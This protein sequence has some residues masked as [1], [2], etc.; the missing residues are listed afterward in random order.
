MGR[1]VLTE[2]QKKLQLAKLGRQ[3]ETAKAKGDKAG[4]QAAHAE[5]NKLRASEPNWYYDKKT[6]QTVEKKSAV[7]KTGTAVNLTGKKQPTKQQVS[8]ATMQT[9][10]SLTGTKQIRQTLDAKAA[11]A[12]V[13]QKAAAE[14]KQKAAEQAKKQQRTAALNAEIAKK[15]QTQWKKSGM[16]LLCSKIYYIYYCCYCFSNFRLK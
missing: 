3:Y 15:A 8:A 4:M 10:R 1:R 5:A 6:G 7:A 9:V 12:Q 14:A 11:K 16:Y 13:Q 2:S